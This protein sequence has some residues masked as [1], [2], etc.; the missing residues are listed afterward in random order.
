[1][2]SWGDHGVNDLSSLWVR[3]STGLLLINIDQ[4]AGASGSA[5]RGSVLLGSFASFPHV[6]CTSALPHEPTSSVRLTTSEKCQNQ[7]FRT[8]QPTVRLQRKIGW[9]SHLDRT[10]TRQT[11]VST[12]RMVTMRVAQLLASQSRASACRVARPKIPRACAQRGTHKNP[13]RKAGARG[14]C[15]RELPTARATVCADA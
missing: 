6:D 15:P 12:L 7:A 3:R 13:W 14:V 11:L 9:P 8:S 4:S 2:K 5:D 10:Q 1:L